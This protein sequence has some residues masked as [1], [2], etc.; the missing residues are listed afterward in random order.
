MWNVILGCCGTRETDAPC[1]TREVCMTVSAKTIS[2]NFHRTP[3]ERHG[4]HPIWQVRK[5]SLTQTP[6]RK[7][8]GG[9][10]YLRPRRDSLKSPSVGQQSPSV[11]RAAWSILKLTPLEV[12]SW[13]STQGK[14]QMNLLMTS[15]TPKALEHCFPSSPPASSSCGGGGW[16][17]QCSLLQEPPPQMLGAAWILLGGSSTDVLC[18]LKQVTWPFSPQLPIR[19]SDLVYWLCTFTMH[20]VNGTASHPHLELQG[21]SKHIK[22]SL[23]LLLLWWPPAS[24]SRFSL[25]MCNRTQS[26]LLY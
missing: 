22:W 18:D 1:T 15:A 7:Q 16:G 5:P 3:G 26:D 19:Q 25:H 13:A 20:G 12:R 6:H 17:S 4:C 10:F 8:E 23:M 24:K 14:V 21:V 2:L 9:R 11:G